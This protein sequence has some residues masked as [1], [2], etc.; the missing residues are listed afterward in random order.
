MR[1]LGIVAILAWAG[2]CA[3][4]TGGAE[5]PA[6]QFDAIGAFGVAWRLGL[7]A[8]PAPD[9][10]AGPHNWY[11]SAVLVG[12]ETVVTARHCLDAYGAAA[13]HAVRFRRKLDGSTGNIELGVA[14]YYHATVS[15]WTLPA[16]LDLAFGRLAV[17]VPHIAP[18]PINDAAPRPA[19]EILIAGWGREGA[20][21][22]T[23]RLRRLKV[24]ASR[25]LQVTAGAI[26]F[27]VAWWATERGACGPNAGDSGGAVLV[28]RTAPGGRPELR[29]V[30]VTSGP[31]IASRLP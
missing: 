20:T 29:L 4:I 31:G 9:P 8:A 10:A 11:C 7:G 16:G 17:E 12:P 28:E 13:P 14:S 2:Q 3:A 18:I 19:S 27:P 1:R 6:V 21:W 30:G 15:D 26:I 5:P 22:A 25:A 24:C 23:G